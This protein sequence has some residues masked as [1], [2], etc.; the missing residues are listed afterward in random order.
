MADFSQFLPIILRNEGGWVDDPAD[1]GGATNKGITLPTFRAYGPRLLDVQPT[2]PQL[3]KLTDEQA[4]KI[5]KTEYWDP[6]FG[7]EIQFELLAHMLCDF[8]VN[9]GHHA[10]TV[11][12]KVLNT[13]GSNHVPSGRLTRK[14]MDSL[15]HHDSAAVYMDYKAARIAYYRTI[16]Q[17]HPVLRRFLRGWI[18]R[19]NSF[20]NVKVQGRPDSASC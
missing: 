13:L 19:V 3:K 5:Y 8:H 16:A 20:P 12:V 9:A 7:D 4:G 18:N 17:E 1:P 6:I 15:N 11:L 10:V 2:I 14:I